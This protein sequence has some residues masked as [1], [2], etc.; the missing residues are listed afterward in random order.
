MNNLVQQIG[1]DVV[2]RARYA[3][4]ERELSDVIF[5]A[6]NNSPVNSRQV[7][8]EDAKQLLMLALRS[9]RRRTVSPTFPI[10]TPIDTR[11]IA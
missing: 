7:T 5:D 2:N 8:A 9:Y 6:V 1:G 11:T 10:D 4:S 3:A